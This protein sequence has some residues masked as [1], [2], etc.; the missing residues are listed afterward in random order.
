MRT[1]ISRL[2][3]IVV[4]AFAPMAAM[5]IATPA[6]S[7]A[8]CAN[9]EWWDPKANVCRAPDAPM[10]LPCDAGQWWVGPDGKCMPSARRRATTIGVWWW[11]AGG[12]RRQT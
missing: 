2:V 4:M 12:T 1:I 6:V 5:T 7:L 9:G 11:P 8:D 10:A 3:P